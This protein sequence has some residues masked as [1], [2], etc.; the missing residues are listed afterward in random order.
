MCSE[1][2][3]VLGSP[4]WWTASSEHH[5]DRTQTEIHKT[6]SLSQNFDASPCADG[7]SSGGRCGTPQHTSLTHADGP[8]PVRVRERRH[9]LERARE[10]ERAIDEPRT[11]FLHVFSCIF[12]GVAGRLLRNTFCCLRRQV[13]CLAGCC[14]WAVGS[15]DPARLDIQPGELSSPLRRG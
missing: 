2:S 1:Q 8:P 10:R 6:F 13:G 12:F 7:E 9:D 4:T 5:V 11:T 3:E 14:G 15:P